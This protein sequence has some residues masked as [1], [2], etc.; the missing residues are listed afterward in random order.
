MNFRHLTVALCVTLSACALPDPSP[1][2]NATAARD[3]A[4]WTVGY[5]GRA[6]IPGLRALSS[7]IQ[8]QAAGTATAS[9]GAAVQ[10]SLSM[11]LALLGSG[12]QLYLEV[13]RLSTLE[14]QL[15][16]GSHSQ[17][18]IDEAE[19]VATGIFSVTGP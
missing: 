5:Q 4:L 11:A 9:Q 10:Q 14:Q 7:T 1:S 12:S 8:A 3:Y 2:A 6:A 19:A 17:A 18:F 16:A 13:Q 15:A